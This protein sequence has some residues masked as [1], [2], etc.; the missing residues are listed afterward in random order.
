VVCFKCRIGGGDIIAEVDKLFIELRHIVV[1]LIH[2]LR[3][4]IIEGKARH[5]DLFEPPIYL[6]PVDR[7][8]VTTSFSSSAF[9]MLALGFPASLAG[10]EV[11]SSEMGGGVVVD[12][13]LFVVDTLLADLER[14]GRSPALF[15]LAVRIDTYPDVPSFGVH[16]VPVSSHLVFTT[17]AFGVLVASGT[18]DLGVLRSDVVAL[19]DELFADGT[20][21]LRFQ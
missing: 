20:G 12:V 14:S 16:P 8:P 21:D 4:L 2:R 9:A 18:H 7:R 15:G 19:G 10:T 6:Q 3:S 1:S 13:I 11:C 17:E 5:L